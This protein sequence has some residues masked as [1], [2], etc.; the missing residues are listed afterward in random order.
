MALQVLKGGGWRYYQIEFLVN[1]LGV[2]NAG[3]GLPQDQTVLHHAH[4]GVPQHNLEVSRG[5]SCEPLF[6]LLFDPHGDESFE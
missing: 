1:E 6:Q 5:P 3:V 4:I 2:E